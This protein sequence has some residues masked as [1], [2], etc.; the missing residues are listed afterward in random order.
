MLKLSPWQS[1]QT[2][3]LSTRPRA[4]VATMTTTLTILNARSARANY[5]LN[6][7]VLTCCAPTHS[8]DMPYSRGSTELRDGSSAPSSLHTPA[9]ELKGTAD[10][11]IGLALAIR[12]L[13]PSMRAE[14]VKARQH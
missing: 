2:A 4:I 1:G 8:L 10:L 13:L 7:N 6:V 9:E 3:G 12:A 5:Q 14:V 11:L